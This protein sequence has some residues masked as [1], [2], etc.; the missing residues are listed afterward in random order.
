MAS[1]ADATIVLR[2]ADGQVK[3]ADEVVKKFA[4]T[5]ERDIP[6]AAA[7]AATG[8]RNLERAF[9]DYKSSQ[10]QQGRL[11]G[12]YVRELTEFVS[13][14]EGARK[15]AGSLGQTLLEV[16]TKGAPIFIAFEAL[17]AGVA[18]FE[19]LGEEA[20]KTKKEVDELYQ[21]LLKLREGQ[22]QIAGGDVAVTGAKLAAEEA[23]AA[24]L[25]RRIEEDRAANAG[26]SGYTRGEEQE[27]AALEAKLP[28]MREG[29]AQLVK[30]H[31]LQQSIADLA[32]QEQERAEGTVRAAKE[33]ARLRE[34]ALDDALKL[35]QL[36]AE[37]STIGAGVKPGL[38]TD[39]FE[40]ANAQF[41]AEVAKLDAERRRAN[42]TNTPMSDA[43][44]EARLAKLR[45]ELGLVTY[46]ANER[47]RAADIELR[48]AQAEGGGFGGFE[49]ASR[50]SL[51]QEDSE[52]LERQVAESAKR[53][54]AEW[55]KTGEAMSQAFSYAGQAVGNV[56]AK[57]GSLIGSFG[58]L[59]GQAIALAVAAQS[60]EGDPYTAIPR[61][62][63]MF[64]ALSGIVA[65][66]TS[67]KYDIGAWE[68]GS[69]HLAMVHR[70]ELIAPAK[71]APAVR[72]MLSG[73]AT[74]WPAGA[75]ATPA[76][77]TYVINALDARSFR[78]ALRENRGE[79]R[80]V[81]AELVREGR[82]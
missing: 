31:E 65:T 34:K 28:L 16:A 21:N 14:G 79:L 57:A 15:V 55:A 71:D 12:F 66:A 36:T 50:L 33:I 67:K 40:Q 7:K 29:F 52:R 44:Y 38:Y 4:G 2:V 48:S 13:M 59:I 25:R 17:K 8:T 23:R 39:P 43:V 11:V 41:D 32:K 82:W 10:V 20:K 27:L 24:E 54:R 76:G 64:A 42:Q 3:A 81:L 30:N 60:S 53:A 37:R 1:A 45:E 51:S 62:F 46:I 69:D 72:A 80:A 56:D 74:P 26:R 63:A 61:A 19:Y 75:A 9:K 5:L 73:S 49:D 58:E 22:L 6:A 77:D 35:A 70:G 78:E 18:V 47:Q 68:I